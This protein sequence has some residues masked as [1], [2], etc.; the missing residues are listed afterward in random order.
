MAKV[1]STRKPSPATRAASASPAQHDSAATSPVQLEQGTYEII[2]NRLQSHSAELSKRLAQLN[3]SRRTVFGAIPT[4][5]LATERV[6]TTNNCIPSDIFAIGD[7]FLFGYNVHIGLKSET[8]LEDVFSVFQFNNQTFHESG[9]ELL[10]DG[11]FQADFKQLYKYYKGT[12][13]ARFHWASPY[14]YFVFQVGKTANDVKAFKWLRIDDTLK[15]VDARSEHEIRFPPQHDFQWTRT[16]RDLHRT[17]THPH[18]SINDVL[19][20]E[21]IGGDLTLKVEDNTDVGTG[22]YSEPVDDSDQGLDDA[23]IF[24]STVG[25]IILLKIRPYKEHAYRYLVFNRKIQTVKRLDSIGQACVL[26][27]EDH[28]LI[29]ANGYYLQTGDHKIFE[30]DVRNLQFDRRLPASNGEDHLYAFYNPTNGE[31]VLLSY[32][33]IEQRVET[34]I[35]CHGYSFFDNGQLVFFKSDS[36]PQKHHALQ[37]WQTPYVAADQIS[38]VN[39]D[40]ILYKIGNRD[41]VRAMAGCH[42]IINL[43]AKDDAYAGLYLDLVKKCT[44]ILD[45]YFWLNESSAFALGEVLKQIRDSAWPRCAAEKAS[46]T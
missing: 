33:M 11:S 17:G 1:D 20:V 29:F 4:K 24:Y 3:D 12:R 37:I 38:A 31:Y 22:I 18:V 8:A 42:E 32:N 9:M 23:E 41:I 7:R 30:S 6:T 44:D 45:A 43:T 10:S 13:F 15:Y 34:P 27:P 19:F 28:G 16:H 39:V 26:L 21:A 25:N 5:L 14:L 46:L 36:T 35:Q 2:R 40:S